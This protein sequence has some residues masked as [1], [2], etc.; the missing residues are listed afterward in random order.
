[1]SGDRGPGTR[2]GSV[3]T[4]KRPL[5]IH[6]SLS[7]LKSDDVK[8]LTCVSNALLGKRQNGPEQKRTEQCFPGQLC[9][10]RPALSRNLDFDKP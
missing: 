4:P 7:G 9:H 6:F 8:P 1:M 5:S 3:V 10:P 2:G